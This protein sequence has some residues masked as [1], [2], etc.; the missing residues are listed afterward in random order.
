VGKDGHPPWRDCDVGVGDVLD[1]W[2][3]LGSQ[4]V[5]S[6]RAIAA[7]LGFSYEPAPAMPRPKPEDEI[8]PPRPGKPP[9]GG[10]VEPPVHPIF[11]APAALPMAVLE[12]TTPTSSDT[13]PAWRVVNDPVEDEQR[14]HLHVVLRHQPLFDPTSGRAILTA[15]CSVRGEQGAI[16][17]D[18]LVAL[19]AERKPILTLPRLAEPSL[20]AGVQI[21]V[22]R[23]QGLAPFRR[24]VQLL[25]AQLLSVAGRQSEV[26][27][28][29][30][31]PS[32][33]AGAGRPSTW[34]AYKPPRPPTLVV[35]VSDLG[36]ARDGTV[37]AEDAW[38]EFL[39][40]TDMA[41][42]EVVVFAPYPLRRW[43]PRLRR[44]V[45]AIH[46]D[47]PTT[48]ARAAQATRDAR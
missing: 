39:N 21:L 10:P 1:A 22:D 44:R 29:S 45:R 26:L 47:R 42:C 3:M 20:R 11:H 31:C 17:L 16:D 28:F 46:W 35:V 5:T 32:F 27:F 38:L 2:R 7:A 12:H 24:D 25:T 14:E 8:P 19:V 36:L 37:L 34:R 43:P 23:A 4:D 9:I 41:G 40:R 33:R 18:R 15:A 30:G 13:V 48:V 6:K